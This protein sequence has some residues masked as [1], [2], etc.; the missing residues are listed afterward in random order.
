M[1]PDSEVS[2][3]LISPKWGSHLQQL[4][5]FGFGLELLEAAAAGVAAGESSA[6]VGS[7]MIQISYLERVVMDTV[8]HTTCASCSASSS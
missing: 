6:K 4:R 7:V 1:Q 3:R 2:W 8:A 5:S